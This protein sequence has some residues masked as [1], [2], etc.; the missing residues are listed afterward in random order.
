MTTLFRSKHKK[1]KKDKAK[2]KKDKQHHKKRGIVPLN[3]DLKRYNKITPSEWNKLN[4][5]WIDVSVLKELRKNAKAAKIKP[6]SKRDKRK[7]KYDRY[8][9]NHKLIN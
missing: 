9:V 4:E 7:Q 8:A 3:I 6:K 5:S 1:L 2:H